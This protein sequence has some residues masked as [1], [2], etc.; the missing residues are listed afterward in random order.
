MLIKPSIL[1]SH[2]ILIPALA[3]SAVM[4]IMIKMIPVKGAIRDFFTISSLRREHVGSSGQGEIM[5]ESRAT[6]RAL[7][8]CHVV[9][10]DSSAMKFDRF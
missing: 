2:N 8:M 1:L 5:Y 10:R 9:R 4:I 7:I 3:L 6:L